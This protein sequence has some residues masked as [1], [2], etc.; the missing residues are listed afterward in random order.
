[1][2]GLVQ[3]LSGTIIVILAVCA[4]LAGLIVWI[5]A[6]HRRKQ[7]IRQWAAAN[8]FRLRED[9]RGVK[10]PYALFER[11]HSRWGRF[12]C[13]RAGRDLVPGLDA[14]AEQAEQLF[15]Y[16]YAITSGSGKSRSTKHYHYSCLEMLVGVDLG[17]V[18]VRDEHLGDKIGALVGM[19]DIDFE[20]AE[21]SKRFF[22]KSDDRRRA[23]ELLHTRMMRYLL[24]HRRQVIHVDGERVFVYR[25]GRPTAES[26]AALLGFIEGMLREVPRTMVNAD[27]ARRGLPP[28]V[29]AG[30]AAR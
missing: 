13:D 16:H 27:R 4:G 12:F 2:D 30:A 23:Y 22:V 26:Y 14:A 15:E 11:G 8:G 9:K 28:V 1:M 10:L 20:D 18:F 5:A 24:A 6:E 3:G 17:H 21:F 7:A 29:E 25:R 19:D